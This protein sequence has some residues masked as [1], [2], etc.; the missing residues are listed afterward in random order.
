[1][2]SLYTSLLVPIAP[3]LI[4]LL[5][6]IWG[7]R[8]VSRNNQRSKDCDIHNKRIEIAQ[9]SIDEITLLAKQYYSLKGSN[10][11]AKILEPRIT[12]SLKK[13]SMYVA[14]ICENIEKNNEKYD[15]A[16]NVLAFKKAIS[17]GDF[18]THSRLEISLSN[19]L[20]NDITD[21]SHEL[22]FNLERLI[23]V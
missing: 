15:I 5:V 21:T 16:L 2:E 8:V 6:T 19:Q 10:P 17:G 13:L 23:K 9:K 1:M 7:W 11:E 12:S 22:I 20:Y 18:G 3:S 14:L 4:T